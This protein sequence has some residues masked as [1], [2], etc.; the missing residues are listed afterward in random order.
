MAELTVVRAVSLLRQ[1]K[2]ASKGKATE[3][4]SSSAAVHPGEGSNVEQ[5]TREGTG[6]KGAKKRGKSKAAGEGADDERKVKGEPKEIKLSINADAKEHSET[7][8]SA[9]AMELKQKR[10]GFAFMNLLDLG[11]VK[12][13]WGKW[14]NRPIVRTRVRALV[15]GYKENGILPWNNPIPLIVPRRF[16]K[17]ESLSPTMIEGM[18]G[19]MIEWTEEAKDQWVKLGDGHHRTE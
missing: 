17:V 12:L 9:L 7:T 1:K 10:L 6:T 4:V 8:N 11:P 15:R 19:P 18:D 13:H 3:R 16:V 14:N 2:T 5:G